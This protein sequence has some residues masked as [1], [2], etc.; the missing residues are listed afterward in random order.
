MIH[1]DPRCDLAECAMRPWI[2]TDADTEQ[3][4]RERDG[5]DI[6]LRG[7][8]SGGAIDTGN[9]WDAPDNPSASAKQAIM[10]GCCAHMH[11]RRTSPGTWKPTGR[12]KRPCGCPTIFFAKLSR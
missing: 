11:P 6:S 1:A 10:R 8:S 5:T 2:A 12:R 7:P 9:A 3:T 4:A